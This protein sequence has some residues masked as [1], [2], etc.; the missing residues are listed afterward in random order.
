MTLSPITSR[1]PTP[2]QSKGIVFLSV[3]ICCAVLLISCAGERPG[4]EARERAEQII[5]HRVGTE[6]TW[7]S[8]ARDFYGDEGRSAS[9]ARDNGMS[10]NEPPVAGSAVRISLSGR[11]V[12]RVQNRLDAARQYNEGLDLVSSGNCAAATAKFE[13][14]VK[15]DP[16]FNDASFNLA[17]SYEKLGFHTKAVAILKDL[18]A[19]APG[20]LDYRYALGASRFGAGDLAGAEKAF[21]E[22]L[23]REPERPNALFSLAVVLE[24]R[25]APGEAIARFQEYLALEPEGE[26]AEA[27]RSHLEELLKAGGGNH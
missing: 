17:V 6:E 18:V 2:H 23:A 4:P 15:L 7:K 25:G 5:T 10:E 9:L 24:R 21:R 26:W 16:S 19:V 20:N 13:E 12:K 22:V 11:D 8:I 3:I 1:R 27:A 14:A